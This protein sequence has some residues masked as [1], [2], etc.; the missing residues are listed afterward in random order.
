M[1]SLEPDEKVCPFCAEV[2][3]AA[4]V[5]CRFCQSDLPAQ[6]PAK[7]K[8]K[9][10]SE[11][12]P[13]PEKE[14]KREKDP[15]SAPVASGRRLTVLLVVLCVVLAGCL[16]FLAQ[17]ALTPDQAPNGQVTEPR[18]RSAAMDSANRAAVKGLSYSYKSLD[19]DRKKA[20]AVMTPKFAKEYAGV[21]KKVRDKAVT[22]KLTLK[23]TVMSTAL[24]SLT[25]HRAEVLLFVNQATTKEG[26]KSQQL[27]QNRVLM[28]MTRQDGD[29]SVSK[30]DAF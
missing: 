21:M 2:I 9:P 18:F 23:A 28:T 10:K 3:K 14:P 20:S 16:A 26:S 19:A 12:E 1:S 6:A 29:W 5:K 27:N 24:T 25:R 11:K 8:R 13:V 22:N 30:M 15:R 7:Q 4:A 17:R